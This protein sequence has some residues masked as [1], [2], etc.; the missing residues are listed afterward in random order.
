MFAEH[1]AQFEIRSWEEARKSGKW[2]DGDDTTD[3]SPYVLLTGEAVDRHKARMRDEVRAFRLG[4]Q[5]G[6][7][8][9]PGPGMRWFRQSRVSSIENE[10]LSARTGQHTTQI[11][12]P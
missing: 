7:V 11:R 3:T 1:L 12:P 2:H 4:S 10:V 9:H 8:T 6:S 5:R